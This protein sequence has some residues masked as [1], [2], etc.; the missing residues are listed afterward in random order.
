MCDSLWSQQRGL[1]IIC[2]T[3]VTFSKCVYWRSLII[4][5][6]N[7]RNPP[8]ETLNVMDVKEMNILVLCDWVTL[9]ER[10]FSA[11]S[12]TFFS[13]FK[14]CGIAFFMLR[15]M[16]MSN[17][18]FKKLQQDLLLDAWAR[19]Q[20]DCTCSNVDNEVL[21]VGHTPL[22]FSPTGV[23]A[24]PTQGTHAVLQWTNF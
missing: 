24:V 1:R 3:N 15:K 20:Q 9:I 12:W 14:F 5:L 2:R 4:G 13:S 7:H 23:Q 16:G 8:S 10:R 19:I 17:P 21:S 6:W 11:Y 22:L 18:F